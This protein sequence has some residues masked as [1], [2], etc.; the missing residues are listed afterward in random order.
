[1]RAR[2]AP[3]PIGRLVLWSATPGLVDDQGHVLATGNFAKLS[4]ADPT[5]AAP[6]GVAAVQNPDQ[7]RPL[8]AAPAQDR[9]RRL[10]HR[11][12]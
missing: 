8:S 9:Q 3:T 2:A 7:D 5:A 12:L 6:Y 11:G 1:M 10:D 4:I